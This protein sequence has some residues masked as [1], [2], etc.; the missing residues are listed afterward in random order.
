VFEQFNARI[1]RPGQKRKM[2]VYLLQSCPAEKQL[3][4]AIQNLR[5]GHVDL[6]E[7]YRAIL[8]K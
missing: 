8:D 1:D 4:M 5:S 7:M 2:T 3:N 6:T